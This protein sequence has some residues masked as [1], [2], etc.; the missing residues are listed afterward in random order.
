LIF[1]TLLAIYYFIYPILC[2]PFEVYT[3][4]KKIIFIFIFMIKC[5]LLTKSSLLIIVSTIVNEINKIMLIES[6]P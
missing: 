3:I 6:L 2:V 5:I 4:I 1:I